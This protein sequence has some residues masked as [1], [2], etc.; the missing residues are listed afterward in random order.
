[1]F[2]QMFNLLEIQRT[3]NKTGLFGRTLQSEVNYCSCLW[4]SLSRVL[5]E[6]ELS[7]EKELGTICLLIQK[8]YKELTA[9]TIIPL[10]KS[11]RYVLDFG[12]FPKI[13]SNTLM[14]H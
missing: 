6:G 2:N 7:V 1:M 11:V 5:Q 9:F 12:F 3:D 8:M 10:P 4:C 13:H 14:P